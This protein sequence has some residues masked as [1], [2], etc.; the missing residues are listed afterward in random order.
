MPASDSS[1]DWPCTWEAHE[2]E[3]LKHG[4]RMTFRQKMQWLEDAT[5]FARKLQAGRSLTTQEAEAEYGAKTK[6]PSA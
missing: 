4:M 6:K 3:Q 1:S 5:D 2:L